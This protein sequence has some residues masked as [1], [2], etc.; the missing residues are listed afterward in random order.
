MPEKRK[1]DQT[2]W[3]CE[4]QLCLPLKVLH[5]ACGD[6]V[7]L[8]IRLLLLCMWAILRVECL[9]NMGGLAVA[10][11]CSVEHSWPDLYQLIFEKTRWIN[12]LFL[13]VRPKPYLGTQPALQLDA[14]MKHLYCANVRADIQGLRMALN[15]LQ[16]SDNRNIAMMVQKKIVGLLICISLNIG[17]W[18]PC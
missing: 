11:Y 2:G 14:A 7:K 9:I 16:P 1:R 8:D 18:H 4:C 13:H 17:S 3:S 5:R 10:R 15:S 6:A 12:A